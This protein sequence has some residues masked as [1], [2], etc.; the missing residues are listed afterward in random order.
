MFQSRPSASLTINQE[1][2]NPDLALHFHAA[3]GV[4]G[5]GRY[6]TGFSDAEVD[7]AIRKASGIQDEAARRAAYLDAQRLVFAKDPAVF[8]LTTREVDLL[9]TKALK[10]V[11]RGVGSLWTA[12]APDYWLDRV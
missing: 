12:F 6:D 2:A 7:A 10:G 8:F 9:Q 4:T 11:R 3:G 1:Y 5:N